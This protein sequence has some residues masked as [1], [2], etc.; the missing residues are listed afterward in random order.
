MRIG[1]VQT[2]KT[3]WEIEKTERLKIF[4]LSGAFFAIIASYTIIKELKDSIFM[5]I[6]GGKEFVPYAKLFMI[7]GLIPL[8]LFYSMLVDTIRRYQL[9]SYFAWAYSIV[10]LVCAVIVGFYGLGS[11]VVQPYS[12]YWFFGWFYYFYIESFSPFVVGVFWAFLNSVSTPDGA[13][14]NYGLLISVSKVGGMASAGLAWFLFA[15]TAQLSKLGLT[16]TNT[17]VFLMILSSAILLLV[18]FIIN[19]M[20]K[21]VPGQYLHGYEEAYKFEKKQSKLGKSADT[22]MLG[23]LLM[24]LRYPYVFGIFCTLFFY[25]VLSAIL[26]YMRLGVAQNSSCDVSGVSCFLFKIVFFT[27]FIGFLISLLGTRVLVSYLGERLSLMVMP[28]VM[29]TL[30]LYLMVSSSPTALIAAF[31]A[32]RAIYYSFNQPVTEALYIPT[33]KDMKFKSKS[34]IDTFGKKFARGAGSSF[35]IVASSMGGAITGGIHGVFFGSIIGIWIVVSY[36]LG[37]RFH[38]AIAHGEVIG[39]NGAKDIAKK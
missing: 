34:W 12:F 30:L 29:G 27:H 17:H 38:K 4:F 37:K 9:L 21:T 32:L 2:F 24:L 35:N 16:E 7:V 28:V 20:M 8:V 36:L 11:Q 31:V 5:N 25:E 3:L 6:V 15:N 19:Q 26:S 18:P 1:I 14:K 22:G 39:A 10:G 33:V 13:K 23:G